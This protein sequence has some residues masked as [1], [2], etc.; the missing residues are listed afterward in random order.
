MQRN[1]GTRT[2]APR[3]H[4]RL[5]ASGRTS[6]SRGSDGSRAFLRRQCYSASVKRCVVL[7]GLLACSKHEAR[8]KPTPA[9]PITIKCEQQPFADSTTLAEASGAAWLDE[10]RLV[11][12]SDSGHKGDYVLVDGEKGDTLESGKLPLGMGTDDL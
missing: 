2:D 10:N 9:Q 1:A 12:V 11:V 5:A 8:Q 6:L 4:P 3:A 7:L